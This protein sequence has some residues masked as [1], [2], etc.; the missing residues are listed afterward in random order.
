MKSYNEIQYN[1]TSE[2]LV[3]VLCEKTQSNNPLFFRVLVGYYFSVMASSMRTT[4]VTHD[5]GD[6]PVNVYALNLAP[7]G[8][9]LN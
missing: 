4:I 9:G 1:T 6:V 7:S 2:R 5:R 8:F 3:D